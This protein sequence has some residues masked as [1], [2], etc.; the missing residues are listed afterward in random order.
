MNCWSTHKLTELVTKVGSGA[1]PRGGEA[2]YSDIG[3][4]LIRSMNVHFEG[5]AYEGLAFLNEQQAAELESVT[6]REHD[7]LLNIT[8][9]SIGR[10]TIAPANLAG[11]RVNQ[12]VCIIR[13]LPVLQSKFLSN[14]L[15]SPK[16]QRRIFEEESGATRQALTKGKILEFDIPLPPVAEQQ[17]IV[18]A[19]D[20]YLSRLDAAVANLEKAQTKLKAYR[21]SVL[22]AAVEGRLVPTEAEQARQEKRDY[23]P[24]SVLLARILKE[25]RRRWEEVELARLKKAGKAPKDD[26]WKAKYEEPEAPDTS[27]LPALP[28]GWCWVSPGQVFDWS[29]GEFLP[30]KA[31]RLGTYPVYGGNGINGFH[32]DSLVDRP[33]LVIGRVGAHCGNVNVTEGSAWITDNAIYAINPPP[34]ANLVYWQIVLAHQNLNANAGGTGQ[35]YVNQK[36]LN[37]L[38][39]PLAPAVEQER[40]LDAVSTLLSVADRTVAEVDASAKRVTRLRQS[41]LK[42]AFEG[43]LVDQDPNDEPAEELLARIRAERASTTPAKKTRGR[44]ANTEA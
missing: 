31:Q 42:W 1:T 16:S 8:G 33:T 37:D 22:K 11:A 19:I 17:R 40:L 6:V 15:A 5:F 9:A 7:V 30:K 3:V 41:I 13:T 34:S 12:H 20:S 4:P 23:E 27:K 43:K 10:V 39:V 21:A 28:E 29:S 38:V 14:Y 36:H 24:A 18:S 44:K 35:P 2:A 26:K 25:R 32:D